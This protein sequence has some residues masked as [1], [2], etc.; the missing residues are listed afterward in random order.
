[1]SITTKTMTV[2]VEFT[3]EL[4]AM[5]SGNKE[6]LEEFIAAKA[7]TVTD[8]Q[9]EIASTPETV[10]KASTVFPKDDIGLFIWDYQIRGFLKSALKTL[11][12]TDPDV[13]ISKWVSAKA[14]DKFLFVN[15]RRVYIL[16]AAGDYVAAPSG[17][18]QRPLRATT[19]Q[20]DRICLARSEQMAVGTKIVMTLQ[21]IE[22]K[23]GV[24]NPVAVFDR[25]LVSAMLN[26]GAMLGIGQWAG[27]GWGRFRW[28]EGTAS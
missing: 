20:G 13:K 25:E 16:D 22:G 23:K 5:S 8:A 19:L 28:S 2:S 21:W 26:T 10:E 4:L 3:T 14:V 12:E 6:I 1:M 27:G 15:P 9:E 18:L 24:K 11:I 17:T 7:P